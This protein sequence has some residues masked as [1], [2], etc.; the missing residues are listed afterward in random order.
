MFSKLLLLTLVIV[1]FVFTCCHT[2][3]KSRADLVFNDEKQNESSTEIKELIIND[4]VFPITVGKIY[5][6]EGSE[7][8]IREGPGGEFKGVVNKKASSHSNDIILSQVNNSTKVKILESSK[9]WSKIVVVDPDWLSETHLGWIENKYIKESYDE[10]IF[11]TLNKNFLIQLLDSIK[12]KQFIDSELHKL[13]FTETMN[14]IYL[15]SEKIE[16]KGKHTFDILDVVKLVIFHTTDKKVYEK[17]YKEL[18]HQ[19]THREDLFEDGY[20]G[21]RFIGKQYSFDALTPVNGINAKKNNYY[22]IYVY[23]TAKKR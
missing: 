7:I 17:I 18:F 19:I 3:N 20:T 12:N 21:Q 10:I 14:S 1:M 6:I 2:N 9:N 5:A 23:R 11:Q 22:D 8:I 16:S 4:S 15:S 13:G